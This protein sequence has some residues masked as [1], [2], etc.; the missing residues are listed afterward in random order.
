MKRRALVLALLAACSV[1]TGCGKR[2]KSPLVSRETGEDDDRNG[3]IVP[4][5]GEDARLVAE[6]G[7]VTIVT[8]D[9][10]IITETDEGYEWSYLSG[11]V[12]MF[13]PPE[14]KDRFIIRD[15]TVYCRKC[16]EKMEYSGELFSVKFIKE[17]DLISDADYAALI[18]G[19]RDF[20]SIVV[21][22]S[23][24]TYEVGDPDLSAEYTDMSGSLPAVFR[25][26]SCL[27]TKG[28]TPIDLS[29]YEA[30]NITGNSKLAGSWTED[31]PAATGNIP[32]AVFRMRDSAFGYRTSDTGLLYGC[33][34]VNKNAPNYVWNTENWGDAG[35]VFAGGQ[36][37]R[38]TYYE[39]EPMKL[40]FEPLFPNLTENPLGTNKFTFKDTQDEIYQAAAETGITPNPDA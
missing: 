34:F 24:A 13:F 30:A 1:C 36:V 35:L 28:F 40:E 17:T 27:S 15:T 38:V 7:K 37:Y 16:Y 12:R 10:S 25:S 14:W 3:E 18:G 6:D 32:S 5:S 23:D 22:P 39:S 20:Y 33:F 19:V 21:L 9:G 29:S 2:I 31:A 11:T 8:E 4:E 26:A